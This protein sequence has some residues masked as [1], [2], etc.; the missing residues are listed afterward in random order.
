MSVWLLCV[1]VCFSLGLHCL[2][3][4]AFWTWLSISFPMLGEFSAN[5]YSTGDYPTLAGSFDSVSSGVTVPFSCVLVHPRL[6]KSYNQI[7]QD[8]KVRSPGDSQSLCRIPRLGSLAWG[9][10]PS[11]QLENFF[12]IAILQFVV[13]PLGGYRIWFYH[14]CA[15]LPS[16]CGFFFVFGCEV[17]LVGSSILLTVVVQQLV[18]ILV[19]C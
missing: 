7:P 3:V 9:S 11:Q 4:Y 14:N 2:G 18:V 1:L 15:L 12:G 19:L 16:C 17:S 13:C 10:E 8:F 6:W 5:I